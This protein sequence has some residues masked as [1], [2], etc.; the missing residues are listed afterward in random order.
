MSL[1][2]DIL[3]ELQKSGGAPVSGQELSAR[4]GVSRSAVW[5]AVNAL[6][7]D[8]YDIASST[9]IG[10]ALVAESDALTAEGV[11]AAL[12]E[13]RRA[14]D[15][16]ALSETN[17]TNN[18]A[19]RLI[20][21]GRD[22]SVLVVSDRQTAGKG[23]LGRSFFSPKGSL[24]MS[25]AFR[26][27]TD[28]ADAVKLTTAAAVAVALAV[29]E[30]TPLRPQIKWVNDVY[31]DGKKICGILTEGVTD[32]E[33]GRVTHMIIGIG[34]N[35]GT[36]DFPPELRDIAAN[37]DRGGVSRCRFAAAIASHLLDFVE[38]APFL[39]LYRERCFVLGREINCIQNGVVTP[40][41]AVAVD[42]SGALVVRLADG[43]LRAL[44]TGE[45][46]IRLRQGENEK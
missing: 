35:C 25:L 28:I 36:E 34:L 33:S 26:V 44:S 29:E 22:E 3:S 7:R 6:R 18:E 41:T 42:D 31:L 30:L 4:F 13:N 39:E 19:K 45:I 24:Y 20:A 43:S 16:E 12:P 38:G 40:A 2:S 21:E 27:D 11:R 37:I 10:Y 23:R 46:S 1:K 32:I 5:K 9:N 17:S 8:G 14:L 15:I